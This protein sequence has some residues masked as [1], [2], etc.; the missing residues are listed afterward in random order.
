MDAVVNN[1]QDGY[2]RGLCCAVFGLSD[3]ATTHSPTTTWLASFSGHAPRPALSRPVTLPGAHFPASCVRGE[4]CSSWSR[5]SHPS[6]R[7]HSYGIHPAVHDMHISVLGSA[8]MRHRCAH[9][10]SSQDRHRLF[11][12]RSR[13]RKPS[14]TSLRS[15]RPGLGHENHAV[16]FGLLGCFARTAPE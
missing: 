8:S 13:W 7:M 3:S 11:R 2:R 1:E 16:P 6:L 15:L 9:K 4:S 14:L 10:Y 12:K 5:S